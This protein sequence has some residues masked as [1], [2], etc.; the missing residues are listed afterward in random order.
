[1]SLVIAILFDFL[2]LDML[3]VA[4]AKNSD[5]FFNIFRHKGYYYDKKLHDDIGAYI[6]DK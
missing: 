2:V 1:L 6:T 4:L 5:V 3:A